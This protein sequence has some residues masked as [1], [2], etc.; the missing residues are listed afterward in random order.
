[1]NDFNCHFLSTTTLDLHTKCPAIDSFQFSP[2]PSEDIKKIILSY[3]SN[4]VEHDGIDVRSTST[5]S[6]NKVV[7]DFL[8]IFTLFLFYASWIFSFYFYSSLPENFRLISIL[9]YFEYFRSISVL[10]FLYI[11]ALFL[12]LPSYLSKWLRSVSVSYKQ[13]TDKSILISED[14]LFCLPLSYLVVLTVQKIFKITEEYLNEHTLE[15][16]NFCNLQ[17]LIYVNYDFLTL[18]TIKIKK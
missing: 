1:M 17:L 16:H 5:L 6:L 15:W 12:F 2:L 18:T 14:F 11:F 7:P 4:D 3:R 8:N 9:P 10:P 13:L